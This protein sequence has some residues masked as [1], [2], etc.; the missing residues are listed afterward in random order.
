MPAGRNKATT[1]KSLSD[2][3]DSPPILYPQAV[4]P[5]KSISDTVK[6]LHRSGRV[7]WTYVIALTSLKPI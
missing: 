4:N 1:S 2:S 7:R 6:P 3:S 5:T